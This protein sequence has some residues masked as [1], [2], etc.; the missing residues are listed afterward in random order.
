M[1]DLQFAR[2]EVFAID[3]PETRSAFGSRRQKTKNNPHCSGLRAKSEFAR[4]ALPTYADLLIH[5]NN[6][7]I[8]KVNVAL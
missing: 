2:F 3:I 4:S 1:F 5:A 8:L 6:T 7:T